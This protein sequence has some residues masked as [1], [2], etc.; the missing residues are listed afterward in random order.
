MAAV[1]V[2][3]VV[4]LG[5]NPYVTNFIRHHHNP[6]YPVYGPGTTDITHQY[7]V[8]GMQGKS[9]PE[10]LA[11]AIVSQTAGSVSNPH[12]KIPFTFTTSEWNVFRTPG[13]R[14]GGW[15]PLFSGVLLLLAAAGVVLVVRRKRCTIPVLARDL[16][17]AVGCSLLVTVVMPDSFVAGVRARVL[18]R[19]GARRP[20]AVAREGRSPR[21]AP[22]GRGD[23][24]TRDQRGRGSRSTRRS[25]INRTAAATPRRCAT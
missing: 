6:L 23:P 1:V 15:G 18:A 21:P 20:G 3:G 25:R 19:P 7:K 5:A 24:R 14:S 16:L 13:A 12:P 4:G 2:V 22:V 8:G 11:I 17:I 9:S 10:R